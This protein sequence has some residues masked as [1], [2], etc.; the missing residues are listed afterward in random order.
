MSNSSLTN[1]AKELEL[2]LKSKFKCYVKVGWMREQ[3]G[4]EVFMV[5]VDIR[6]DIDYALVP[7]NWYGNRINVQLIWPPGVSPPDPF[8]DYPWA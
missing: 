7:G 2:D 4:D 3:S 8:Q 5:Y 6:A 1:R